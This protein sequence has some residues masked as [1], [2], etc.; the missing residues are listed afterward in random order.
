MSDD[1]IVGGHN[2]G[3]FTTCDIFAMHDD[4][5]DWMQGIT[6][7]LGFLVILMKPDKANGQSEKKIQMFC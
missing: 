3:Y 6:F 7:N 4:L 2:N 5:L 1:E